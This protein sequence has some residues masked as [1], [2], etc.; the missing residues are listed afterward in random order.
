[1][2]VEEIESATS[3][4][5]C[6]NR[7][8]TA[9][10]KSNTD[11]SKST[12]IKWPV[13]SPCEPHENSDHKM[14]SEVNLTPHE[15][16]NNSETTV[17]V[18]NGGSVSVAMVRQDRSIISEDSYQNL[19]GDAEDDELEEGP[20]SPQTCHNTM[21]LAECSLSAITQL[22]VTRSESGEFFQTIMISH[23]FTRKG[24]T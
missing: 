15:T 1:M 14:K 18:V 12:S 22:L 16:T 24:S 20:I 23:L 9:N 11:S 7:G 8:S 17:S 3:S 13:P 19:N 21:L 6:L 2:K 10:S 4:S 5:P